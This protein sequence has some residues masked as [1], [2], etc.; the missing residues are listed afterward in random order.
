MAFRVSV[1]GAHA[2]VLLA[3]ALGWAATMPLRAP[4]TLNITGGCPAHC[5]SQTNY[6]CSNCQGTGTNYNVCNTTSNDYGCTPESTNNCT[7][8]NCTGSCHCETGGG[9][10]LDIFPN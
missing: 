10:G 8:G 5:N 9:G 1:L 3:M 2:P 7:G 6:N 4:A